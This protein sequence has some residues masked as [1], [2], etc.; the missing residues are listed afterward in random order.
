MNRDEGLKGAGAESAGDAKC[1]RSA[2]DLR[3]LHADFDDDKIHLPDGEGPGLPVLEISQ[4]EHLR[5]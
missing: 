2:G 4:A 3:L 1:A 5:T